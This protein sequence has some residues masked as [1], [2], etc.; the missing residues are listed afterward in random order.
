MLQHTGLAGLGLAMAD[1]PA[2]GFP[3]VWMQAQEEVV[4]FTDVPEKFVT[5]NAQTKRVAG[6]DLRQ[7]DSYLTPEANYFVV[8]HYG[9]PTIDAA[10][11]TLEVRGRVAN[12][13][14]YTLDEL[15]KRARAERQCT[16]ECGG[17]RGT[18]IMNRRSTTHWK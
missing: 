11:W 6:L 17:N 14:R 5:V 9:V 8:A 15:K 4:P 2:Y 12:P 16:F 1:L 13:R 10:A 18:P 7:L 3:T